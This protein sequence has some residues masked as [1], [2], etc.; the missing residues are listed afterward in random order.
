MT[1]ASKASHD[2]DPGL[3]LFRFRR[4]LSKSVFD[5]DAGTVDP[6]LADSAVDVFE[7]NERGAMWPGGE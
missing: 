7:H 4:S 1:P 2:S 5:R 3:R 6:N